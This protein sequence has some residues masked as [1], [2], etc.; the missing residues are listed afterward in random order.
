MNKEINING[1]EKSN[2]VIKDFSLDEFKYFYATICIKT[3]WFQAE[4]KFS[5]SFKEFQNLLKQIAKLI[6]DKK[7]KAEFVDEDTNIMIDIVL[8]E[9]TGQIEITGRIKK[10]MSD[11]SKIEFF[12]ESDFYNLEQAYKSIQYILS[13]YEK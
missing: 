3:D 2:L 4:T 12:L 6:Q 13:E 5:F 8:D 1:Y 9:Y 11:E 7:G 10:N